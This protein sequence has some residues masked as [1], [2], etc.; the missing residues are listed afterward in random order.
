VARPVEKSI[1]VAI[2]VDMI[3]LGMPG[4]MDPAILFSPD[5]DLIPSVEV[6]ATMP[7]CHVEAASWF[8]A[9]RIR[10]PGRSGRGATT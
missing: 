6:L 8:R 1:D 5:N 10:L 9:H 3:R 7:Q 4:Y 2:A